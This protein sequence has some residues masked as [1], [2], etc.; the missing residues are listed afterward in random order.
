MAFGARQLHDVGKSGWWQ[1]LYFVL[2]IGWV[3]L[4]ISLCQDSDIGHNEFGSSEKYP[5]A[6]DDDDDFMLGEEEWS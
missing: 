6:N 4:I 5:H 3:P 1:L 2:I